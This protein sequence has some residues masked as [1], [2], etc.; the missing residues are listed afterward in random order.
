MS[1]R[2]SIDGVRVDGPMNDRY[3][4]VLTAEALDFLAG[5]HRS[6][7]APPAASCSRPARAALRGA[8]RAAACS[9]S[10]PRPRTSART[11]PGGSRRPAP[12]LVDR[13]V[14]ITGP[15]DRKMTINALN[16][17]AKVWLADLEDANTPLWENVVDGQLNLRDAIERRIDFTSPEGKSLRASD[18]G[19]RHHRRP[20][21]RLA[22]AGEAHPGRR[23]ARCRAASSTSGST[24]STA[25][26]GRSTRGSGPYFYLPKMESHL[27]ARL[28]NDVFVHA[29]DALGIPQR[30][31][32]RHRADRDLPGGVRDG[33]DPL[34][35]A[36]ALGRAQ[37]RPL[38]L[39]VQRHQEV[40]DPRRGLPAARPQRGDD[41]GAVHARLHRAAGAHLPQARRARDRRHGGVHPEQGRG[42]QRGRLRQ[43]ARRQDP[44]GGRRLRRLLG[45][46]PRPWSPLAPRSST[47]CSA[48]GRTSS[49]SSATTSTSRPSSCST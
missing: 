49:T 3:D 35:A 42:G 33:G 23:R 20:A 9:T 38:G 34:R 36:R 6:F 17:G 39:H 27:E 47:P 30:H 25:R 19:R 21:A 8:R 24:S 16:S 18:D 10:W 45:R 48:T 28:W 22:P 7:D 44:R 12:G 43:G 5:L 40:P 29:Q 2:D 31:H 11:T 46:A 13:R 41:D 14:E 1:S 15:T 37:R 4:E 26:S 32:P